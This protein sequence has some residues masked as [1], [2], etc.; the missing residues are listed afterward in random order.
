MAKKGR[1]GLKAKFTIYLLVL[2]FIV[3]AGI[4]SLTFYNAQNSLKAEL[5]QRGFSI[6]STLAK[7]SGDLILDEDIVLLN[8]RVN[9]AKEFTSV[10]YVIIENDENRILADTFNKNVP[11]E[12]SALKR[13]VSESETVKIDTLITYTYAGNPETVYEVLCP[14]E[15]GIIGYV[16]VGLYKN[17]I[18]EQIYQSVIFVLIAILVALIL[19]V[20]SSYIMV[21]KITEPLIY[22]TE[23]ADKI[24]LGDINYSIETKSTDEIGD[25]GQ[26]IE[27]MRESLKAAIDR[28]KKRQSMRI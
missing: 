1:L 10:S 20:V 22:L 4:L 12:I 3:G 5:I 18:D 24:S 23:S 27:R 7:T 8:Q 16:R 26:A 28:L 25:L 19:G 11:S 15:E 2:F 6:G 9:Y 17:Y 13:S 14:V 21:R